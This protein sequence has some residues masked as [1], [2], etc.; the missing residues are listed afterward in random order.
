M[1]CKK[2]ETRRILTGIESLE[3]RRLL[4]GHGVT[5]DL[6]RD[7]TV[8]FSDFL[9][10]SQS[11]GKNF[12]QYV[13]ASRG[14][15]DGD[16]RVGF[17]DF[18]TL[19]KDF[20]KKVSSNP[21]GQDPDRTPPGKLHSHADKA[22]FKQSFSDFAKSIDRRGPNGELPIRGLPSDTSNIEVA[23][24]PVIQ[25]GLPDGSP[26]DSPADRVDANVGTSPF[27]GV[28]SLEIN[29]QGS[30]FLCTASVIS[31][32]QVLTA[33]HCFD[34]DADGVIHPDVSATF[35][36]NANGTF[37]STHSVSSFVIH[38]G[39][40]GFDHN[41]HDDWAVL[42][43]Q[44]AVPDGTPAYRISPNLMTD[45]DVLEL[46]G[47]GFSGDGA[48]G[49]TVE[50]TFETKRSGSNV[51]NLFVND[52]DG[53]LRPEVFIFD[54]DGPAGA[55][56]GFLG[57]S[58]LGNDI[59]TSIGPGDSGGPAFVDLDGAR[60]IAG[61]NTFN[62]ELMGISAEPGFFESLAGGMMTGAYADWL[63]E[64]APDAILRNEAP[65]FTAGP[66]V[67]V[68]EDADPQVIAWAT[69][70]T[71]GESD[72]SVEFHVTNSN[73][74]LFLVQPAISADGELSF[75]LNPNFNGTADVTVI[76]QDDGG[77]GFGGVDTSAEV[78]FEISVLSVN[79]QPTF[80]LAGDV[81]V[82]VARRHS[83]RN[84]LE[85]DPGPLEL[86]QAIAEILAS[87]DNAQL[88][89]VQPSIN[90]SGRLTFTPAQGASG[91]A[92]VEVQV[93]DNGG[94]ENGG[95]DLSE[96]QSFVI[97]M[98]DNGE[99]PGEPGDLSFVISG[100]VSVDEDAGVTRIED[101]VSGLGTDVTGFALVADDDSLFSQQPQLG[102]NGVLR[103]TPADDAWGVS[104]VMIQ[105][106]GND[107]SRSDV[108]D[109]QIEV[110]P[111]ND[112]P[113]ISLLGDVEVPETDSSAQFI[114]GFVTEFDPGNEHELNQQVLEYI[115][116]HDNPE[117][118]LVEPIMDTL[119]RLW[120]QLAEG[121]QGEA[122]VRVT[123]RDDGGTENGGVDVSA[124]ESFTIRT[125]T[126]KD[127]GP[128]IQALVDQFNVLVEGLESFTA[129]SQLMRSMDQVVE[130]I[131]ADFIPARNLLS[132]L[133]NEIKA[134]VNSN[135]IS[136]ELAEELLGITAEI[137]THFDVEE[138]LGDDDDIGDDGDN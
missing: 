57:G 20:G 95:V 120:F 117:L 27:A 136:P 53:E 78:G 35:Y 36:L 22:R 7:G 85:F 98:N 30:T 42:D 12:G 1:K 79:D 2:N 31:P 3:E 45:G 126:I 54:F 28:G 49:F 111:V 132:R 137:R 48:T 26:P 99:P 34:P 69:D 4:D 14:D 9:L 11:F 84:F 59:E 8:G 23:F 19:S 70:I 67:V 110:N 107:G 56:D 66:D 33:A 29:D 81:Q 68:L 87:N 122:H 118:F 21:P 71:A 37:S 116:V 83:F 40:E 133:D 100:D 44:D 64:V 92:T 130:S 101:F 108:Q 89:D 63:F 129:A 10:L 86:R 62:W 128:E 47:Y 73:P 32:T 5:P 115:L 80:T 43:L 109:F 65:S 55:A 38:P 97:T 74:E 93:R 88:F 131:D 113:R 13:A 51:A 75:S 41:P 103:F 25:A 105:A 127:I 15:L 96:V 94:T 61:I 119:G 124:P 58:T 91:S 39:Y 104:N 52:D 114:E 112:A 135:R 24:Y 106:V 17:S 82:S 102:R 6:D 134:T 60:V 50:P 72:Q 16:G 121:A 46:V 138:L 18:L 77:S 123:A 90:S 76:L 125:G